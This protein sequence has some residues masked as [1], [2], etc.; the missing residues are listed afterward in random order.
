MAQQVVTTRRKSQVD[1]PDYKGMLDDAASRKENPLHEEQSTGVLDKGKV[2]GKQE[3]G[4]E[5][6]PPPTDANKPG[7]PD[8]PVH[9]RQIEE[10]IKGQHQSK[11]V[12]G[13]EEPTQK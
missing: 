1:G 7:P 12:V 6:D 10:F 5:G 13:I 3:K 9:D 2:L 8:R 4:P 11:K